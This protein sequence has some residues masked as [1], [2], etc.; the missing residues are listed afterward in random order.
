M[1]LT[2]ENTF[3]QDWTEVDKDNP[4]L[5]K[6]PSYYKIYVKIGDHELLSVAQY[7]LD[8]IVKIR[9]DLINGE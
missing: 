9:D 8:V 1:K 4:S 3:I 2:E 7:S 6:R 5:Q